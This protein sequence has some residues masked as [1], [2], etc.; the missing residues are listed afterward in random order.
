M[1]REANQGFGRFV[2]LLRQ[3]ETHPAA[4]G[5]LLFEGKGMVLFEAGRICWAMASTA[6]R[7][8][9]GLLQERCAGTDPKRLQELY[10][11]CK[12]EG[13]P[14][15]ET[16]VE[17]G[18][19]SSDEFRSALLEHTA[20]AV[21]RLGLGL[22]DDQTPGRWVAHRRQRYDAAFTFDPLEIVLHTGRRYLPDVAEEGHDTLQWHLAEE[23]RG[24]AFVL[25][26]DG[27]ALAP[28]AAVGQ[29]DWKMADVS[30]LSEWAPRAL[31]GWGQ[32]NLFMT[33]WVDG[34]ALV[35]WRKG[36]LACLAS[37]PT[38]SSLAWVL[39]R[40]RRGA[41]PDQVPIPA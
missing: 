23:S 35:A 8:L 15:G 11:R 24:I 4:S 1:T 22:D 6:Q 21:Y 19:I 26:E 2:A 38:P 14:L 39:G 32:V 9:T 37:C 33:S 10:R 7:T 18:V 36:R 17:R 40:H 41:R 30:L 3:L 28:I 5:A 25:A 27:A 20:E 29:G 16:L 34:G 12:E 31:P 13:R